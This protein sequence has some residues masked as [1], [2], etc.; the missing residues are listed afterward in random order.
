M[1]NSVNVQTQPAVVVVPIESGIEGLE[2]QDLVG[3]V[4]NGTRG[5]SSRRR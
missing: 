1:F 4:T 3:A 2:I 5:G